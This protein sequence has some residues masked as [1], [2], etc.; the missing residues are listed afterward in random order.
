MADTTPSKPGRLWRV[1]L[2]ISLALNLAIVGLVAGA[3]ASGRLKDGPPPQIELGLGPLGRA[4]APDERRALR[5]SLFRDGALRDL[6]LRGGMQD[7]VAAL[8]ADPFDAAE[9]AATMD[10]QAVRTTELQRI[11]Q[12]ALLDLVSE[13]TPERRLEFAAALEA[14]MRRVRPD[15]DRPSGG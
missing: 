1:I 15:R 9:M 6:N 3:A 7:V 11:I 8:G 4:L 2:A 12:A 10:A 13:M 5:R 14:E